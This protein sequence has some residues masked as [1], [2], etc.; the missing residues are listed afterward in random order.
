[1][2]KAIH[3]VLKKKKKSLIF[4]PHL[5]GL[6]GTSLPITALGQGN[7]NFDRQNLVNNKMPL[8]N[9]FRFCRTLVL[10]S[11]ETTVS[12]GKQEIN[13][14]VDFPQLINIGN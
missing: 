1:M 6:H 5:L 13:R 11:M 3:F 14:L 4:V 2:R 8:E 12:S 9:Q 10:C 7:K